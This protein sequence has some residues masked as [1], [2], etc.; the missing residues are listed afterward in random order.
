M[1]ISKIFLK[2]AHLCLNSSLVVLIPAT[3]YIV[4]IMLVF[5]EKYLMILVIPFLVYSLFLFHHYLLN[6][7]RYINTTRKIADFKNEKL[8]RD[9]LCCNQYIIYFAKEERELIF[10]HPNGQILAKLIVKKSSKRNYQFVSSKLPREFILVDKKGR[11]IATYLEINEIIDV[12]QVGNG[13]IGG[14]SYENEETFH[15]LSGETVG[16]LKSKLTFMDDQIE[17]KKGQVVFRTLKGWMPVKYQE[18]FINPNQ[19]ILTI[20]PNVTR[21]DRIIYLSYFVKKFFK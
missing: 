1:D 19:P 11:H 4:L 7:R 18:L 21:I 10:L 15:A 13:Y 17:D 3:F 2:Q 5:S 16:I 20:N 14:Y 12:Y 9:F 6:Y 8:E